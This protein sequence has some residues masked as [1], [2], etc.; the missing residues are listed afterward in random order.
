M[1]KSVVV[2]GAAGNIG[3][4]LRAYWKARAGYDL[5]L[6]DQAAGGDA[7]IV[8]A[9]LSGADEKWAS[10]FAGADAIVHLAANAAADASWPALIGPNVLGAF[11]VYQAAAA[12]GVKRIVYASSVWAMGARRHDAMPIGEG[13]A[14][15]GAHPYGA[16]KAIGERIGQ[17]FVETHRINTVALRLGA[18]A[19]GANNPWPMN[20]WDDACWVSNRDMCDGFTRAIEAETAGFLIANLVSDNPAERWSLANARTMLGYAPNDR[21]LPPRLSR[22]SRVARKFALLLKREY[23]AASPP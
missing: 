18:C 5:V 20:D 7:A 1:I 22:F 21:F 2:T 12:Q 14:E 19:P 10:M 17:T 4:K 3:S 11:N 6:I 8:E 9:D 16:S 23:K 15:P 13:P